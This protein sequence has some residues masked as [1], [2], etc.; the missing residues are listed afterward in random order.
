MTK[1]QLEIHFRNAVNK[2]ETIL[3]QWDSEDG[4]CVSDLEEEL[5]WLRGA[6][7][8]LEEEQQK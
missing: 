6:I 8:E 2:L 4:F 3:E 5:Y 7:V 1:G